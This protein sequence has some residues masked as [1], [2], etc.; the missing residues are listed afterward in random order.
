MAAGQPIFFDRVAIYLGDGIPYLPNGMIRSFSMSATYNSS[1][2][3]GFSPDGLASGVTIGNKT[4]SNITWTEYLQDLSNFINLRTFFI[5]NP[6]TVLTVVPISIATG[7]PSAPQFTISGVVNRS[8][9]IS[10]AEEGSP[11]IRN[12]SFMAVDSSNT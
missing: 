12:C 6:N 10:A 11:M 4:I 2:N 9:D 5:A 3:Q 7:V 8:I 1:V